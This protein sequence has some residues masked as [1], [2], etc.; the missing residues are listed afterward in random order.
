VKGLYAGQLVAESGG[1]GG[2]G[3]YLM[4]DESVC[5]DA[6]QWR[7]PD[8][9]VRFMAC[10]ELDRQ[11]WTFSREPDAPLTAR[12]HHAESGLCLVARQAATSDPLTLVACSGSRDQLWRLWEEEWRDGT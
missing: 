4:G 7:D 11:R 8:A 5:L 9:G 6:P 2:D 12:V 10:A 1:G 3:G